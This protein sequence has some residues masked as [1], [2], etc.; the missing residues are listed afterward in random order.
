MINAY[1]TLFGKPE[2][3]RALGR[4]RCRWGYNIRLDFRE[5]GWDVTS[6]ILRFADYEILS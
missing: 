2:R 3:K 1:N 6:K 4:P 5:I